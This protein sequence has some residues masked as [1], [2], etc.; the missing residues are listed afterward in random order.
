MIREHWTRKVVLT[1]ATRLHME[2]VILPIM[3]VYYALQEQPI[4]IVNKRW[5]IVRKLKQKDF[6]NHKKY[7]VYIECQEFLRATSQE[8][9]M[10]NSKMVKCI[11]EHMF[12]RI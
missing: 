11:L 5:I 3:H 7:K 12:P 10:L 1:H 2:S 9:M 4:K 8:S 6:A